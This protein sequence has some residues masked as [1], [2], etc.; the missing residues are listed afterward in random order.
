MTNTTN[1]VFQQALET[2]LEITEALG[3]SL[4]NEIVLVR[5]LRGRIRPVVATKKKK[6]WPE[7]DKY[8]ADLSTQ[9][10][11]YAFDAERSVLF[12]DEL[13]EPDVVLSERRLLKQTND[14]SIYLLDRQI[15][16][17]DWMRDTLQR[18][19]RNPRVTFFGLKGGV[20]RSTAL[21]NWAWHLAEQGKKVL[22]FDLD[23]ESPGISSSL[24]PPDHLPDYGV[25][26]WFVED[27]VGQAQ[28]VESELL[29]RSPL[30]QGL[31]GE[32]SVI[33]AYGS[34]TD[35]YLPKLARCYAE[36][37]GDQ[38]ESWAERLHRFVERME[39][40]HTPDVVILDSRAGLHD[41]AAVLATRMEAITLLFAIDTPQTWKGYELLFKHWRGHPH[42][43]TFRTNLQIIAGMVPDTGRDAYLEEFKEHSWDVFRDNLYDATGP[44]DL[45]T[46]SFDLDDESAPHAPVPIFWHRA[47]MEFDPAQGGIDRKTADETLS[48][49]FEQADRLLDTTDQG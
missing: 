2:A 45:D 18:T 15:I 47:L 10:G 44:E 42:L 5:D 9:L 8:R 36:F 20:G 49:F 4:G 27:G 23:L 31:D 46:F 38:P 29:A 34:K 25:V 40:Q 14:L 37:S 17:Q 32:I 26:D 1:I 48:L 6:D 33:P 28:V 39:Q 12:R 7:L 43:T 19:T 24:L 30:S 3:T 41:I 21:V 16:G 35:D 11:A 22:V 13:T